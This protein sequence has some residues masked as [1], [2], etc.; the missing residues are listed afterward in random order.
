ALPG[1]D[2]IFPV[3]DLEQLRH[4][5][6]V[7]LSRTVSALQRRHMEQIVNVSISLQVD[8]EALRVSLED[9]WRLICGMLA[10]ALQVERDCIGFS[11]GRIADG[12]DSGCVYSWATILVLRRSQPAA[13]GSHEPATD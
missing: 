5:S 2:T 9:R 11:I 4:N 6:L 12:L 1:I 8:D 13:G 10:S 3:E 7:L